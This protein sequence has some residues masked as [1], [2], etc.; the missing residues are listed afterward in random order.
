MVDN[1]TLY[2]DLYQCF[3]RLKVGTVLEF[4]HVKTS[5]PLNLSGC[6]GVF[7]RD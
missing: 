3:E 5:E 7:P 2:K 6:I 1:P 4:C